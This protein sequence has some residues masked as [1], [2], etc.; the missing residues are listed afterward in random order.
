M[1]KLMIKKYS[2]TWEVPLLKDKFLGGVLY[3]L[4]FTERRFMHQH[5]KMERH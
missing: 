2:T 5:L 3:V 4:R 1:H